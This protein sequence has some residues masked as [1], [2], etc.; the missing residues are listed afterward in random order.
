VPQSAP[1]LTF[2]ILAIFGDLSEKSKKSRGDELFEI[3]QYMPA[4]QERER[5]VVFQ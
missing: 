5:K 1:E 4:N 2:S 3:V